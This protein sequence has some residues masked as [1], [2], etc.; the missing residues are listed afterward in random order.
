MIYCRSPKEIDLMRRAAEVL[1]KTF[2]L[3]TE[4]IGPG[5]KSIELDR[6]V[7]NYIVGSGA[8]PAFKGYRGFPN[9]TC[10]SIDEVVVHGIPNDR[11][12]ENGQLVSI[13]IGVELNGYFADAA[14]TYAIGEISDEKQ[15]LMS[16]TENALEKGIN[17]AVD[18][19]RISNISGA[20]Q[21]YAEDMGFSV[22]RDL[23]GHGIGQSLHEDPEIPNFIDERKGPQPKITTG[24]VFAIEP[25]INTGGWEVSFMPDGWTIITKD[26]STSAHFEHTIAVTENGPE[27][28]T[29]GR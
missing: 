26:F 18:G 29:S 4:S 28:L 10:I 23:V 12:F 3:V 15:K 16:V 17:E 21:T 19:N 25:M 6:A 20:I 1:V 24:M 5:T 27:I 7:E 22:V 2:D 8:K 13:D 14:R 11:K 9:S